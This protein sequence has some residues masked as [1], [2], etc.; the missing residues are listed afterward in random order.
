MEHILLSRLSAKNAKDAKKSLNRFVFHGD[1]GTVFLSFCMKGF[2][3]LL[4]L[5]DLC[6]F[7]DLGV[8]RGQKICFS[9]RLSASAVKSSKSLLAVEAS[10]PAQQKAHV[11]GGAYLYIFAEGEVEIRAFADVNAPAEYHVIGRAQQ[12]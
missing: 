2:N 12:Q 4:Q 1:K 5:T 6:F 9:Q 7:R 10:I 3:A 11:R 8:F